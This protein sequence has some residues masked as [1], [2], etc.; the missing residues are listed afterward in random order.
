MLPFPHGAPIQYDGFGLDRMPPGHKSRVP[1]GANK[2]PHAPFP[3]T[4]TEL[5][6]VGLR[7]SGCF[8]IK[9]IRRREENHNMDGDGKPRIHQQMLP[10]KTMTGMPSS[11][12]ATGTLP[13]NTT[14]LNLEK[15]FV[16][17]RVVVVGVSIAPLLFSW[18]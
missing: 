16:R 13:S 3:A 9:E 15:S 5:G 17:H 11:R 2:P 1:G 6:A 18:E 7:V 12:P 4:T 8:A 14:V 10:K